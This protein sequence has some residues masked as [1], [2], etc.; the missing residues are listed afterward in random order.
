MNNQLKEKKKDDFG[1]GIAKLQPLK[2]LGLM[3]NMI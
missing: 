1:S 3:S 2:G